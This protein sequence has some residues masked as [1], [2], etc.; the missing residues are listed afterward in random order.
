M[1]NLPIRGEPT[2]LDNVA[3]TREEFRV[4]M[5][6]LLEYLAQALGGVDGP[7][8]DE[9]VDPTKVLLQGQPKLVATAVP[10]ADDDSTRVPS[11]AWVRAFLAANLPQSIPAGFPAWWPATTVPNGWVKMNGA[12]LS[13]TT[14]AALFGAIGTTWGA[15]DGSTTFAV[16]DARGEFIRGFA[17]GRAGVD[18]G[19]VFAS[20]Q[21]ESFLSHTHVFGGVQRVWRDAPG[22]YLAQVG[23][24][25]AQ[26]AGQ[27]P[28]IAAT[29]GTET[30][31][32]NI[33]F[34]PII[35]F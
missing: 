13:R 3:V 34:M 10:A 16:P 2:S 8:T 26:M 27:A 20:V 14:Y 19:R 25:L 24:T 22:E 1:T 17:D 23:G 6:Q 7:F 33:P 11:T 30:R 18:P 9:A 28:S 35:K 32:R 31:P 4:G 15:G 12:L 21:A 29:G 5:G